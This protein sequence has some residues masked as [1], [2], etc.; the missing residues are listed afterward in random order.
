MLEELQEKPLLNFL[1]EIG[2]WPMVEKTG[3]KG[4]KFNLTYL[5]VQLHLL[6]NYHLISAYVHVDMKNSTTRVLYV[7]KQQE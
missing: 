6:N 7:S 2:G 3:W 5:L 4:D 1:D